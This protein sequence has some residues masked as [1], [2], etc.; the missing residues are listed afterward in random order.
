MSVIKTS[1]NLLDIII[2]NNKIY[3][4]TSNGK[5]GY[6]E[7]NKV[8]DVISLPKIR[9]FTGEM[10]EPKVFSI[11]KIGDTIVVASEGNNLYTI[12]NKKLTKLNISTN[13]LIKKAK[14]IDKD[15]VFVALLSNEIILYNIT[16]NKIIYKSQ[17]IGSTFSDFALNEDKSKVV[18]ANESGDIPLISTSNGKIIKT[19]KSVN[20]DNIYKISFRNNIIATAGQD[21][22]TTIYNLSNNS[23][24][25]LEAEFLVYACALS[26]RFVAY[27]YDEDNKIAV[28]EINSKSNRYILKGHNATIN[29]IMFIDNNRLISIADEPKI[30]IWSI[31]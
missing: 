30:I 1:G 5:I 21:R 11:D 16:T 2:D 7:S 25:R 19:L 22:K 13:T 6:I 12:K 15:R 17:L 26:D 31:K 8:K 10:I 29:N 18:V 9:S 4:S 20:L 27:S 14:F 28:A 3:F 23:I 24:Y